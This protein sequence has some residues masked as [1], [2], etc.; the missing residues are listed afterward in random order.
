MR[1]KSVRREAFW[2][3]QTLKAAYTTSDAKQS[4]N[5]TAGAVVEEIVEQIRPFA[6]PRGLDSL[7]RGVRRIVKLAADTWRRARVE[8][9][10][11]VAMFPEEDDEDVVNEEWEEYQGTGEQAR[12][13]GR[14][15]ERHVVLR[16]FPRI[17]R[18]AAHESILDEQEKAPGCIYSYG[19]VLYTD[20]PVVRARQD[21]ISK[22][23]Y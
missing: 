14:G 17:I 8:R 16:T 20:S 5:L 18:E 10:V 12:I 19:T 2:R 1:R 21:E 13:Q 15:Y 7:V 3:Q 22:R 6:D 11:V 4:I 9:E 23:R